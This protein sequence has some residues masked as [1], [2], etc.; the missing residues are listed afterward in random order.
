MLTGRSSSPSVKRVFGIARATV[1]RRAPLDPMA[2]LESAE[3]GPEPGYEEED[4]QGDAEPHRDDDEC[5][6]AT[7]QHGPSEDRCRAPS[8]DRCHERGPG[9][10]QAGTVQAGLALKVR[11]GVTDNVSI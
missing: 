6:H 11:A 2:S 8:E 5:R 1:P 3:A 10:H 4:S 7:G 9:I